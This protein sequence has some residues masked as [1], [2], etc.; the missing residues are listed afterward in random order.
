MSRYQKT[1]TEAGVFCFF[2]LIFFAAIMF[3][4][5]QLIG[6]KFIRKGALLGAAGCLS[7]NLL[8]AGHVIPENMLWLAATMLGISQAFL[9]RSYVCAAADTANPQRTFILINAITPMLIALLIL[10]IPVFDTFFGKL[11][12][13]PIKP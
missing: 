6:Q 12:E 13:A 10:T 11:G 7:S 2:D 5:P 8:L 3:V 4:L 1:A 9:A